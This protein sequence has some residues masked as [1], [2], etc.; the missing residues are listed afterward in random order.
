MKTSD[1]GFYFEKAGRS[2][3]QGA[4]NPSGEFFEGSSREAALARETA[5]NSIDASAGT[6]PVRMEFELADMYV[7]DIP[8]VTNLRKHIRQ[9]AQATKGKSGNVGL[10]KARELLDGKVIKTLRISDYNTTGLLGSESIESDSPLVALTRGAGVS[11][12]DGTR[13]GSFGIGSA[14]GTVLSDLRTVLYTSMS[15]D[16]PEV[17]FAGYSR[18]ATHTGD[19]GEP[20]QADGFFTDRGNTTDFRYLRAPGPIGPFQARKEHGTDL[21]ILGYR[22]AD[23]DPGLEHLRAEFVR[24]FLVAIHRGQLGVKAISPKG[25]WEL[26]TETLGSYVRTDDG[27]R[28]FHNAI[29]DPD[30]Y[31]ENVKGLGELRLYAEISDSLPKS[32]YTFGVRKPLM[33]IGTVRHT[34]IRSKYAAIIDCSNDQANELLRPMEPPTHDQWDPARVAGGKRHVDALKKFIRRGLDSKTEQS[35]GETIEIKGLERYLPAGLFGSDNNSGLAST[36]TDHE[37]SKKETSARQGD[38]EATPNARIQA[39]KST[40][41]TLKKRAV[42]SGDSD[43]EKGKDAGGSGTRTSSGGPLAGKGSEGPGTSRIPGNAV[44]FRSWSDNSS[45]E[46]VVAVSASQSQSGDIELVP[47]GPNGEAEDDYTLPLQDVAQVI[48]GERIDLSFD[49]NVIKNIVIPAGQRAEIRLR[50]NS[51]QRYRLGMR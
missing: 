39:R 6:G 38:P 16:S 30:P 7:E 20:R 50:L 10:V 3:K 24:S 46:I 45:K 22:E 43:I 17:V 13:G 15:T 33:R 21:Y 19:D 49:G 32:F 27:T 8:D 12:N 1:Y 26:N 23:N 25:E 2:A 41:A 9:A 40:K 42:A 4:I 14:V 18:L 5:Q 34:S 47:L 35:V 36:P 11:S 37:G 51:Q 44:R 48:D 29:N 31:I 28:A